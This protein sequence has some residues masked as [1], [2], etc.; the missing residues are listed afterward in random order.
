MPNVF[1]KS[2]KS[3]VFNASFLVDK[4]KNVSVPKVI[5]IKFSTFY[6]VCYIFQPFPDDAHKNIGGFN[7]KNNYKI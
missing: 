5:W 1:C 4:N 7:K 3:S 6:N 2:V